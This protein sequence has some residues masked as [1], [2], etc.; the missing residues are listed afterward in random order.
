MLPPLYPIVYDNL[1]AVSDVGE[2]LHKRKW[3][4]SSFASVLDKLCI[5]FASSYAAMVIDVARQRAQACSVYVI[6][7]VKHDIRCTMCRTV[8]P[9][10][11]RVVEHL[12]YDRTHK[13]PARKHHRLLA[14]RPREV[15]PVTALS[16][17]QVCV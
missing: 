10:Y 13:M 3:H 11:T 14:S 12:A 7:A 2:C 17:W 6:L 8:P 15:L 1:L 16:F 5:G 4:C 9:L